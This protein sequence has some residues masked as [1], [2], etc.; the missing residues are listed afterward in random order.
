MDFNIVY[1]HGCTFSD[2]PGA[3]PGSHISLHWKR[4]L[5]NPEINGR[6]I[7]IAKVTNWKEASCHE[8]GELK[9]TEANL[10]LCFGACF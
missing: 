6:E 9:S 3:Q 7:P 4:T 1:F 10:I 2:F 5:G 8:K